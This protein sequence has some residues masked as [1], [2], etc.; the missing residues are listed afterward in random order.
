MVIN[1]DKS[2]PLLD[3]MRFKKGYDLKRIK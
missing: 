3:Y 2:S 1:K